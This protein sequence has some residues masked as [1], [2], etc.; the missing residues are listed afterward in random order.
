MSY[1]FLRSQLVSPIHIHYNNNIYNYYFSFIQYIKRFEL[2]NKKIGISDNLKVY[3]NIFLFVCEFG[4]VV[5]A[6]KK[7][8]YENE[9]RFNIF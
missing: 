4:I 9:L 3:H 1:F 5:Y 8:S 7:C 2:I 6:K